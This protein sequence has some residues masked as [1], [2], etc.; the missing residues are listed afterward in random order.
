MKKSNR[1][2]KQTNDYYVLIVAPG[3]R[4]QYVPYQDSKDTLGKFAQHEKFSTVPTFDLKMVY[5]E[6]AVITLGEEQYLAGP[7]VI[8][9]P[10]AD[11]M[12]CPLSF[13]D[14]QLASRIME[15]RT[16][17]LC[18]DGKEFPAFHL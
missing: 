8:F 17:T 2:K 18:A 1:R 16:V 12:I 15:M 11:G 9:V 7:A 3:K 5:D 6:R 14:K 10:G 13:D 4:S